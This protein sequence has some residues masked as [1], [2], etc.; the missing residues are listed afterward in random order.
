MMPRMT[1][2]R[3]VVWGIASAAVAIGVAAVVF[4]PYVRIAAHPLILAV[5]GRK[6]IDDRLAEHGPAARERLAPHFERAGVAYPP[7]RVVMLGLKQERRLELYA[8]D[9]DTKPL[10]FIR[11]YDVLAASGGPGP[12]LREGDRQVPEGVYAIES[13]NPN[14]KFHLSLRLN[15]PN[16]FDR[17]MAARDGRTSLGGDIMI[18]GNAMSVGCLAMGDEAAEDLFILAAE[19]GLPNIEVIVAPR[20]FRETAESPAAATQPNWVSDLYA[21]LR[22]R[23]AALPRQ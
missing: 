15:Y 7:R 2:R 4:W 6:T 22:E 11:A 19:T 1:R 21:R 14:S 10:R 9:D 17:E 5:M 12:K 16:A 8:S 23:I 13:L 18:H 3:A 20:D